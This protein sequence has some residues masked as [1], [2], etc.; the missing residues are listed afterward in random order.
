MLFSEK[1]LRERFAANQS[2]WRWYAKGFT[3]AMG[4]AANFVRTPVLGDLLKKIVLM[5]DRP[6]NLTQ[7]YTFDLNYSLSGNQ[8]VENVVLPIDVI[9]Q[10]IMASSYRA[11]MHQCLCRTGRQCRDYDSRLGC[12]FLGPGA[13]ATVKNG[14]AREA[15]VAE[16]LAHLEKAVGS[17][18][19]G[20]GMWI[21]AENYIW[22]IKKEH[23]HQWLEICFCCPCCCIALQNLR[24]VTPDVRGRF[25]HMGWQA[26]LAGACD[27][28]GR[29]PAACPVE[30]IHMADGGVRISGACLGCGLCVSA[31]PAGALEV[32]PV[33]QGGTMIQDYFK[34]FRPEL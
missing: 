24:K 15:T 1:P 13:E 23:H 20:M 2:N 9:R 11:I 7:A 4:R 18:L 14:V 21:E 10:S 17:G 26:R 6:T 8:P 22:G 12:I 30:A 16:S 5:D 31:C 25:R 19:V 29:C 34:G 27:G 28:C 32:S 3:A 33:S